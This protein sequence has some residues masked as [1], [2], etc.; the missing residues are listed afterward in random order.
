[1]P[2][3]IDQLRA[4]GAHVATLDLTDPA[5]ATA[6]LR[7]AFPDGDALTAALRQA[8]SAGELPLRAASAEV[9]F[10]RLA[11]PADAG[12]CSIDL[13]D[14]AGS[15]AG[16]THPTGEVSWCVPWSGEPEFEGV[17][18]GW[19]VL[20]PTSHHVPTVTGG[21]MLI[22]YWIPDGKVTWDP[23]PPA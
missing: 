8:H 18:G 4:I 9:S 10:G 17:G 16:H 23:A 20:P 2:A 15:G 19:A 1:M 14:I 5:A 22:V 3:L 11:R 21:R 6:A 12:G 13:V 7:A